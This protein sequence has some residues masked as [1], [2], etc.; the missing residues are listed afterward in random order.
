M[1]GPPTGVW[2]L[3]M[4]QKYLSLRHAIVQEA[5]NG[6][7]PKHSLSSHLVLGTMVV[8]AELPDHQQVASRNSQTAGNLGQLGDGDW[9]VGEKGAKGA[10]I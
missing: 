9:V 10:F 7:S 5:A 2:E 1:K 6:L 8:T 4:P 3:E